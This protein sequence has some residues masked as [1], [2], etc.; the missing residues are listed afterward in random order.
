[1]EPF[2]STGL[3]ADLNVRNFAVMD[4][5]L[6]YLTIDAE[7]IGR[8]RYNLDLAIKDGNADL[9]LT[10]SYIADTEAA[11]LDLELDLNR[12][13]MEV[14]QGFSQEAIRN[15]DGYFTGNIDVTGTTAEPVYE[16]QL[17]FKQAQFTVATLNA[18]FTLPDETLRLD[19]KGFY[20]D[21]FEI[22][23]MNGNSLFIDGSLLTENITNPEFD[24]SFRTENF[25]ALNSTEE[26]NDL[27]YGTAVFDAT[28]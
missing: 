5:P 21:D 15:V 25:T 4:V 10:G 20:L 6:G 27:F 19:N 12:I 28:G 24:L 26:D 13:S 14:L 23:D 18:P 17:Q 16:G 3:L 1:E 8:D 9:D 11:N 2:G 7:A 22:K